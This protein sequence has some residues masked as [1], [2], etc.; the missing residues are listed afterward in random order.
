MNKYSKNLILLMTISILAGSGVSARNLDYSLKKSEESISVNNKAANLPTRDLVLL[1]ANGVP[2]LTCSD[3]KKRLSGMRKDIP[4]KE[5]IDYLEKLKSFELIFEKDGWDK[6][7][8]YIGLFTDLKGR[9][10]L[11]YL[12]QIFYSDFGPNLVIP[13][14]EIEEYYNRVSNKNPKYE[15]NLYKSLLEETQDYIKKT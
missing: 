15:E 5:L 12:E 13:G 9:S 1:S 2:L 7:D 4:T 6:S 11:D 14:S 10:Y 8:I 3:V